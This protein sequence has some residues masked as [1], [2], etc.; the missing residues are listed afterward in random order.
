M[1]DAISPEHEQHVERL[2]SAFYEADLVIVGAETEFGNTKVFL[3]QWTEKSEDEVE[4]IPL[5]ELFTERPQLGEDGFKAVQ[6]IRIRPSEDGE[7]FTCHSDF[8]NEA[9]CHLQPRTYV[10]LAKKETPA[11]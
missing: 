3:A 4:L 6:F 7:R 10:L 2:L 1:S 9:I 8:P 5:A 11:T